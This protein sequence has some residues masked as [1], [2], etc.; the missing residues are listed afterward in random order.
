MHR[1]KIV[2]CFKFQKHKWD[3]ILLF[4]HVANN[5]KK[6]CFG[7]KEFFLFKYVFPNPLY[8]NV[9]KIHHEFLLVFVK[10]QIL[11]ESFVTF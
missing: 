2:H 4:L 7:L 8:D 10:M 11:G 3:C 6:W 9:C 5:N 1:I